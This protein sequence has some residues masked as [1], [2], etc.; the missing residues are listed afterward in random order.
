[1]SNK[2]DWP[3]IN[4]CLFKN[5]AVFFVLSNELTRQQF[6]L[7]LDKLQSRAGSNVEPEREEKYWRGLSERMKGGLR[8][9][10]VVPLVWPREGNIEEQ[11]AFSLS[12]NNVP[13]IVQRLPYLSF[14]I[15]SIT[16]LI[17][18]FNPRDELELG[19]AGAG[20]PVVALQLY[21]LQSIVQII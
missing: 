1:M 17:D 10:K 6:S 3:R 12:Q 14:T 5:A 21:D 2:S 4:Y 19:Y 15:D 7:L 11:V 9:D 8:W 16:Y 18:V 13:H 20:E